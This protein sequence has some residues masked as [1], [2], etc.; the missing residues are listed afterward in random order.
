MSC[1]AVENVAICGKQSIDGRSQWTLLPSRPYSRLAYAYVSSAE[2]S[3]TPRPLLP[4]SNKSSNHLSR[5][6]R[7]AP[8]RKVG[9][10]DKCP[11]VQLLLTVQDT[12]STS[13]L[14]G[15]GMGNTLLVAWLRFVATSEVTSATIFVRLKCFVT[16]SSRSAIGCGLVARIRAMF[17]SR[18][19]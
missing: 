6:E 14:H 4:M 10:S 2:L 9:I 11:T 15:L 19:F 5:M 3:N 1:A 18:R 17:Q 7:A 8:G 12:H 16:V 13:G